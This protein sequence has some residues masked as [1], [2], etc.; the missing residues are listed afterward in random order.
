MSKESE[1]VPSKI[2]FKKHITTTLLNASDEFLQ[3]GFDETS[4]SAA[5]MDAYKRAVDALPEGKFKELA[6]KL[7]NVQKV[8]SK[9]NEGVIGFQ[10]VTWKLLKPLLSLE[11]PMIALIPDKPFAKVSVKMAKLGGTIGEN[12]VKTGIK[13]SDKLKSVIKKNDRKK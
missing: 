7:K 6:E 11:T 2:D 4:V 10:D 1:I 13:A 9:L 5:Q 12:A 8:A 3:E